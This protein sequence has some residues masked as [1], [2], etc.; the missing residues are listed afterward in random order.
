MCELLGMSANVPTDIRF[1]FTGLMQRGGRT[2]P[3]ADGWGIAFYDGVAARCFHDPLP[4][5]ESE[6]AKLVQHCS[7][8]STVVISHIRRAN[9][10]RVCL[11]NTHPFCRE[12]WGRHWVFAHNGQIKGIKRLPLVHYRPVGTTDSEYAFCWLLDRI[13]DAFPKPPRRP[14]ALRR[15]IARLCSE[16]AARGVFNMLLSDGRLLYAFCGTR[17]TWLTRRA[18]FGPAQ[19]T[20][21]DLEV[22]F[23]KETTPRDVVTVIATQA[24]T[25]N[26]TWT[27]MQPGE[28]VVFDNGEAERWPQA[29]DKRGV[30]AGS[31]IGGRSRGASST[32]TAPRQRRVQ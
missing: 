11:A 7:I 27:E 18:P 8:K 30:N 4:S 15:L 17:L 2:G 28:L 6:I 16:L 19:L 23:E 25:S 24:L 26:E 5:C 14:A 12:L 20:D 21:A 13:R 1:S 3:H 29:P 32:D 10:G 31:A 22:D 9:R